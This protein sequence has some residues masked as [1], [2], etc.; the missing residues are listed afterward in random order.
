[1]GKVGV[2]EGGGQNA[3]RAIG[4]KPED[5]KELRVQGNQAEEGKVKEREDD[6]GDTN[7]AEAGQVAVKGIDSHSPYKDKKRK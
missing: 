3:P 5:L 2:G 1:M 6:K 4:G 7:A